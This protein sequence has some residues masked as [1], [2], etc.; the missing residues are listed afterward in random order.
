MIDDADLRI[1]AQ[2]IVLKAI[3][4]DDDSRTRLDC[5]FRRCDSIRTRHHNRAR[6]RGVNHC[7]I[8]DF[9]C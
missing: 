6:S 7:F 1:A 8:A 9:G 4:A 5:E 3:V 2:S